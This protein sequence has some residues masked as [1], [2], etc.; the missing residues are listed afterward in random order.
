MGQVSAKL[1]KTEHGFMHWCAGC[2]D[3][4]HINVAPHHEGKRPNWSFD[5]DIEKPTFNPSVLHRWGKNVD[6]N[7][8]EES[9]DESGICHYFIRAGHIEYC[10]DCTHEL[11]G[12]TVALPDLPDYLKDG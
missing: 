4:H 5:G 2:D 1:R 9:P 6:P 8:V 10:G 7:F 3:L 11:K 12:R